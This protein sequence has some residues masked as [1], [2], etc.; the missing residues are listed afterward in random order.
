[1]IIPFMPFLNRSSILFL[2]I[3][4]V[5]SSPRIS[6]AFDWSVTE[7]QSNFGVLST[8]T[9]AG[10]GKN[11]TV[12]STIEHS[13]GWSLG[14]NYFFIDFSESTSPL[15][16]DSDIYTEYYANFSAG[17]ILKRDIAFGIV[18]DL[19]LIAGFNW[20]MDAKVVKFLPGLRFALD[21]PGFSFANLD[22]AAYIDSSSGIAAGGAP[23]QN[24]S[25]MI[26]F[27]WSFPF[28]LEENDFSIVGHI[29]FIDK[30]RDS[31][32][33]RLSAHLMHQAQLRW[34]LG[35]AVFDQKGKLFIGLEWSIWFNKL[36]DR[37]TNEF[38]PQAL[39]AF[40]F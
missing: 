24:N 14:D 18:Q 8:H 22:F 16:N 39:I 2:L 32:G 21:L 13:N 31:F 9:F 25:Y 28:S 4:F 15:Y 35:K 6:F 30:R 33:N 20:A 36:G 17:K 5:C 7:L 26:D 11:T 12:V 38:S 19:G 3:F 40:Q 29:E 23:K 37:K 27:N 1:M 10:G 34:D